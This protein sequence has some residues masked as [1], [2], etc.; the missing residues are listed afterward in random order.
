MN[1]ESPDT[2]NDD[3]APVAESAVRSPGRWSRILDITGKTLL[4]TGLLM[5]AFVVYQ[6]W[7]TG[8]YES[9]AQDNLEKEFQEQIA[10]ATTVPGVTTIVTTTTEPRRPSGAKV[11][12]RIQAPTM[13]LDKYMVAGVTTD[14][15]KMGPGL[16]PKSPLPGQKGNVAITGHRTT[17]GQPFGRI[18]EL[19]AGDQITITTT[20][21]VFVYEVF[22][23]PQIVMPTKTSVIKTTDKSKSILTL[24]SCHPRWS[25]E[26]RIV[27][28]AELITGPVPTTTIAPG[29]AGATTTSTTIEEIVDDTEPGDGELLP[30]DEL[31]DGWFHDTSTIPE[32]LFYGLL[33]AA[34]AVFATTLVKRGRSRWVVYPPALVV[35]I[36][37]L[38][39][40]FE[41]LSG[42][43]PANL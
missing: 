34:I 16:F 15:L 11:V 9:R 31:D 38:Y 36:V 41:N 42:L 33:L 28:R 32:V 10:P 1:D 18:H 22:G 20:K 37:L 40:F 13:G 39:P 29:A 3:S 43:L 30:G 26:R 6:L 21:G 8:I 24:I 25:S 14:L 19:K 35:F 12:G 5:L 7:G 27:V 2:P 17:Y 4:T 23:K